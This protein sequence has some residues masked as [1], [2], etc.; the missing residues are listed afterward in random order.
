TSEGIHDCSLDSGSDFC[1]DVLCTGDGYIRECIVDPDTLDFGD[2]AVGGFKSLSFKIRNDSDEVM[3]G[4]LSYSCDRFIVTSSSYYVVNP[5]DST[6]VN[7]MFLPTALG[8]ETCLIDTGFELC[9]DVLCIGNGADQT[10]PPPPTGFSVAYSS[11]SGNQLSWNSCP[12]AD[13]GSF[14]V[15][16]SDDPAILIDAPVD[17]TWQEAHETGDTTWVDAAAGGWR[18]RYAV[19]ALD[20]AGN[21]SA[22]AL[23]AVVTG[24]SEHAAPLVYSLHPSAPNPFNPSTRVTYDV[25]PGGGNVTIKV[26][27]VTGR[28]VMTLVDERKNPG[29]HTVTWNGTD[30][31]GGQVSTGVYFCRMQ[32]PGYEK[33]VKMTLLK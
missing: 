13:F 23:P 27:D 29:R 31:R 14:K 8:T 2:V 3:S 24:I 15:Y 9:K 30:D 4:M 7:V 28:L 1:G 11:G 17:T 32:A 21:E 10:P 22:L 26:Y 6:S 19:T 16:R 20:V 18:Y 25:P 5:G 33:T 12:A